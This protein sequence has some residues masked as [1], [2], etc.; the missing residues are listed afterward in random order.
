MVLIEGLRTE[1]L[2]RTISNN[3]ISPKAA[4]IPISCGPASSLDLWAASEPLLDASDLLPCSADQEPWAAAAQSWI[5][6]CE[7][8]D[9]VV[10]G[11]WTIDRLADHLSNLRNF[12]GIID[13]LHAGRPAIAWVNE[14]HALICKAGRYELFSSKPLVPNQCGDLAFLGKLNRDV[15]IDDV[16]KEIGELVGLHLRAELIHSDI[17]TRKI[18]DSLKIRTEEDVV[19]QII[20]TIHQGFQRGNPVESFRIANV[21]MFSWLLCKGKMP[22]LDGFPVMTAGDSNEKL[23]RVIFRPRTAPADRPLAP[24]LLWPQN[25]QV[26]ADL[27]PEAVILNECY[28]RSCEN[29]IYWQNLA[30]AGFLHVS[31]IYED[32][33]FV[34][35]FLPDEPLRDE[36]EKVKPRSEKMCRRT[37]IAWLI[38]TDRSIVDRARSSPARAIRLIQFCIEFL[39]SSDER[40]FEVQTIRCDNGSDHRYYRANWLGPLRNRRWIPVENEKRNVPT[41]ENLANLLVKEHILLQRLGEER[42]S[43]FF[44]ILGVSPA[45]LVLRTLGHDDLERMSLVQS[46]ALIT[47]ATGNDAL[48]VQVLAGAIKTDP[49]VLTVIQER[50]DQIRRVAR[51][52]ELGALVEKLFVEALRDTGLV[53]TRTGTGHDYSVAASVS[54]QEDNVRIEI[55]G[56]GNPVLVEVKAT[57]GNCV[58]MSAVQVQAA[59]LNMNRFFLC[60]VATDD[61]TLDADNFRKRVRFVPDIGWRLQKLWAEYCSLKVNMGFFGKT[62]DGLTAEVVGNQVRFRVDEEVWIGGIDFDAA[63][64]LIKSSPSEQ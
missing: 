20:S 22:K 35:Q 42:V 44:Q 56:A 15:G 16:L 24:I 32:D 53:V 25:A 26:F 13:H 43:K 8:N 7:A 23:E 60:A 33:S 4:W 37:E 57:T 45:D 34:D 59:V 9:P 48:K 31:P 21:K 30:E 29:P 28:L 36:E 17:T 11:L 10:N 62:D 39:L 51:N 58:R 12:N 19:T 46:L 38:K 18:I 64:N 41:A 40:A 54:D 50:Q 55:V 49:A 63:I 14:V 3:L 6:F 27:L 2:L 61:T 5:P 52:Q 1:R 47:A